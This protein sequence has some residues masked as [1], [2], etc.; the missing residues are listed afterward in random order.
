MRM[1]LETCPQETDKEKVQHMIQQIIKDINMKSLASP[2]VY[3][4][5]YPRFNEGLTGI[6][7]IETSH[8]AFHF[9]NRPDPRILRTGSSN[10]LLEFDVY[11]CG[12]LNIPQV[13]RI[14]H[15]LTQFS[16]YHVNIT[17]LNR[18]WG[19]TIDRHLKWDSADGATW[20][21]WLESE[22]FNKY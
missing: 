19:L 6:A 16:P 9:W 17:L 13:K 15:H 4:M 20:N 2:H 11:T 21:E 8:I 10:C 5:K 7:P 22:R 1:E 3:Y 14:L 18:N 12:T